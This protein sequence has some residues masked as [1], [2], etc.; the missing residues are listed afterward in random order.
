MML[1]LDYAYATKG[2]EILSQLRVRGIDPYHLAHVTHEEDVDAM[3]LLLHVAYNT[4]LVT[5]RERAE[6][7]RQVVDEMEKFLYE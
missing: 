5:R 3:D 6:K 2:Q 7:L 4:P 1:G